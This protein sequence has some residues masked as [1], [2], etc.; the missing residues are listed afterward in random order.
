MGASERRMA[1]WKTLCC[2]RQDTVVHLASEFNVRQR[3][4]GITRAIYA[5]YRACMANRCATMPMDIMILP[6]GLSRTGGEPCCA[7]ELAQ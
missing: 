1:I 2:R 3:D 5:T 7:R 4:D 6:H